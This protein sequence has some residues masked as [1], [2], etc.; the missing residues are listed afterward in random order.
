MFTG[1]KVVNKMDNNTGHYSQ[2]NPESSSPVETHVSDSY[3][4]SHF[5]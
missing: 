1:R 4:I 3:I 5:S 2:I